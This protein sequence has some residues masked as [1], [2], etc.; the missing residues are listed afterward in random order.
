VAV[1]QFAKMQRTISRNFIVSDKARATGDQCDAK[2]T[3]SEKRT[4]L[5]NDSVH[6]LLE[7]GSSQTSPR[8]GCLSKLELPGGWRLDHQLEAR[9]RRLVQI[10]DVS[11]ALVGFVASTDQP[12]VAV[13]AAWRGLTQE[14][15]GDRRWWTL[16]IGHA[17]LQPPPSVTFMRRHQDRRLLRTVVTPVAVDGLWAMVV[18]GRQA[19]V[20]LRQGSRQHLHRVWPTFQGRP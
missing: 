20:R 4:T 5:L 16:A 11:R 12:I 2:M 6:D 19:T 17:G 10:F 15:D 3:L 1:A 14:A 9:G 13:G 7:P 8:F 18:S